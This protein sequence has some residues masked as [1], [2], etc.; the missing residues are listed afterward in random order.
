MP[1]PELLPILK[2]LNAAVGYL[3][4]GMPQEAW[5]E[6]EDIDAK[7]QARPEVL[8][9]RVEVCRALK[10]WEMMAEASNHLREIEPDEVGHS[11]NMAY[12]TRRFKS[13][14]EAAEILSLALRRYYDDALVRYNLAC[15]WCVMGRVEEAREMLGTAC[16]RDESL[17]ELA[18]TDEDLVGLR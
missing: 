17:R 8:K 13:E 15:Y 1:S 18:E 10:Q 2:R 16:R 11:L 7:E 4:L 6:L 12:A 5:N 14:S 3:N 9:V